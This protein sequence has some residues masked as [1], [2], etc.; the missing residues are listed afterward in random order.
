MLVGRVPRWGSDWT[1]PAAAIGAV[2][3]ALALGSIPLARSIAS[4]LERLTRTVRRFGGGDLAARTGAPRAGGEV[5]E[6]T[7]AF[8]EMADRIETL[9][10]SE[11]E[12]LANVSHELRTPLARIRIALELA[13]EGDDKARRYLREIETDL[14][15]LEGMIDDVLTAARLDAATGAGPGGTPPLRRA[16]F[17]AGDLIDAAAARFSAHHAEREL[18]VGI[19]G[20]LPDLEGDAKLLRRALANLLDNAAKY[21]DG[22]IELR[23]ARA[24]GRLVIEVVDT[25]IGIEPAD[26]PRL[27][28]PFFR[29]DR[30][31]ARGTGG[32][33]LGLT[34]TRRIVEAHGGKVTVASEPGVRTAFKIELPA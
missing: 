32:I 21:S 8:D 16:H 26:L 1:R 29:T 9:I 17:P 28:T 24:D 6:L 10:R 34:L 13:E 5:G 15:E 20:P 2:L 27:F 30:S 14:F 3:L 18:R 25:G 19:E 4:P 7:R 31:R 12:L 22:P 11:K 33:G 23:A